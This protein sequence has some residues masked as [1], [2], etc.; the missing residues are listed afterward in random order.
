MADPDVS[1]PVDP[2]LEPR[3]WLPHRLILDMFRGKR[4]LF[5]PRPRSAP[6]TALDAARA[7]VNNGRGKSA[8]STRNIAQQFLWSYDRRV[9]QEKRPEGTIHLTDPQAMRVLAHATRLKLLGELRMRGPQTVGMLGDL[10]DE[11]PGSVSYHLGKLA[12]FG[13]VE[14]R[15]ELAKDRRETWWASVHTS[16]SWK[17]LE[18]LADP[19]RHAAADALRR[20]VYRNYLASLEGYLEIEPQLDPEWVGNAVSG[21]VLLD[22][23]AEEL[24]ELRAEI[25]AVADRWKARSEDRARTNDGQAESTEGV[26]F[27][28][29][30]FRRQV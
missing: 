17:P 18:L 12:A 23:T 4:Q 22:L 11:A 5:S 21:D 29:H 7:D 25:T 1:G 20:Q 9:T 13:F 8:N 24:G 3:R 16:T 2:V 26:S 10:V 19:Q 30:A 28:F 15:P 27:I 14:Q 6:T